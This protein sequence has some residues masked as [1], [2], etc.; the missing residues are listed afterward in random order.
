MLLFCSVAQEWPA[1][2]PILEAGRGFL[3]DATASTQPVLLIPDHTVDGLCAGTVVS[4]TLQ[5]LGKPIDKIHVHFVRKGQSIRDLIEKGELE[6]ICVKHGVEHIIILGQGS[7]ET[8]GV[9]PPLTSVGIHG[10]NRKILVIDRNQSTSFPPKTTFVTSHSHPPIA[11]ASML[12]HI[13]CAVLHPRARLATFLP[14]F[15]G[16]L[17]DLPSHHSSI[18]KLKSPPFSL[19]IDA[20]GALKKYTISWINKL[21]SLLNIFRRTPLT[22]GEEAIRSAWRLL[23]FD[24][25]SDPSEWP[26][27]KLIMSGLWGPQELRDTLTRLTIL[28]SRS[29]EELDRCKRVPPKFTTD[30]RLALIEISSEWQIQPQLARRWVSALG[31]P[32]A[33]NPEKPKL[34]AVA[35]ANNKYAPGQVHFSVRRTAWASAPEQDVDLIALLKEYTARMSPEDQALLGENF[36]KGYKDAIMGVLDLKS[37]DTYNR[38]GLKALDIRR[39]GGGGAVTVGPGSEKKKTATGK[40]KAETVPYTMEG[41]RA[42]GIGRGGTF[43]VRRGAEAKVGI[44]EGGKTGGGTGAVLG[45]TSAV[46]SEGQGRASSGGAG[47]IPGGRPS[48]EQG[49]ASG[50]VP[51][52]GGGGVIKRRAEAKVRITAGEK[53]GGEAVA[54]L[55]KEAGGVISGV[56]GEDLGEGEGRGKGEGEDGEIGGKVGGGP[57]GGI[58]EGDIEKAKVVVAS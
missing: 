52:G 46:A 19:Y 50:E 43:F 56:V 33:M 45:V 8:E 53:T 51:D 44:A 41:L 15:I 36:A 58:C 1:S 3:K 40:K 34:L 5:L 27:P 48:S 23:Q 14:T 12:S 9:V 29:R 47:G 4:L 21:T 17:A 26:T 24:P 22:E 57:S 39:G 37:W 54:V 55:G 28:Q 11:P 16:T 30:E 32:H 20:T 6:T 2:P 13:L 38:E 42:L 35:C 49:G 31:A 7:V 25:H 18:D 10:P